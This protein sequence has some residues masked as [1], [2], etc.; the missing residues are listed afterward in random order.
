MFDLAAVTARLADA[1]SGGLRVSYRSPQLCIATGSSDQIRSVVDGLGGPGVRYY[2]SA[3]SGRFHR[4]PWWFGYH[5]TRTASARADWI[6]VEKILNFR[7]NRYAAADRALAPVDGAPAAGPTVVVLEALAEPSRDDVVFLQA[8]RLRLPDERRSGIVLLRHTV[9]TE[10]VGGSIG[11]PADDVLVTLLLAGGSA[12][13]PEF[14]RWSQARAWDANVID[15][16]TST[17]VGHR[18][19]V[20]TYADSSQR[21][22]AVAAAGADRTALTGLA[23]MVASTQAEPLVATA[24]LAGDPALAL[25]AFAGL[26][27][28]R[29]DGLQ[30]VL[31]YGKELFRQGRK[32]GWT[33]VSKRTA[34]TLLLAALVAQGRAV[35]PESV[36][37]LLNLAE[38]YDLDPEVRSGLAYTVGQSLAKESHARSRAASVRCFEYA[39]QCVRAHPS[40]DPVRDRSRIAAAHNGAALALFRAGDRSAA[41]T[42]ELAGL[43][44]L[45]AGRPD[46]GQLRDQQILLLTNVA[47]VH[48]TGAASQAEALECYRQAWRIADDADSIAGMAYVAADLVRGLLGEGELAEARAVTGRLLQRRDATGDAS[49]NVERAIVATCCAVAETGPATWYV[50]AVRRMRRG[51]PQLVEAVIANVRQRPDAPAAVLADLRR[52]LARHQA[53]ARDLAALSKLTEGSGG[54]D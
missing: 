41:V 28:G 37:A 49:R 5:P 40:G 19:L 11:G 29:D 44:A 31:S 46:D 27:R 7:E 52:E 17:R 14:E 4:P 13:A 10:P 20:Y 15:A 47:K 3:G 35:S 54:H 38:R 18:G 36:P 33:G 45:A 23:A 12:P 39:Q 6:L 34:G 9:P 42:A 22:R 43:D 25:A 26:A 1:P 32:T 24:L 21:S 50:E 53:M 8:A 16:T 2:L 51:A 48:R 30:D